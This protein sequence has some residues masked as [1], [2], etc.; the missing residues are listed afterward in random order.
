MA[1]TLAAYAGSNRRAAVDRPHL[2]A[3]LR[4]TSPL[5]PEGISGLTMGTGGRMSVFPGVDQPGAWV[6]SNQAITPAGHVF[7]GPATRA[8]DSAAASSQ[9]CLASLGRLHLRQLVIY[10]P[11]GRFWAFQWYETASSWPGAGPGGF[12]SGGS[13]S[14]PVLGV[15]LP[16]R[17]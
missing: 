14:P 5:N 15:K 10:Q 1:A 13:A 8:C 6:I 16:V 7:T 9:A 3:P 2:M 11:A 17:A 4:H 12:L